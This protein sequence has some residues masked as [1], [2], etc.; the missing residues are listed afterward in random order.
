LTLKEDKTMV[1]HSPTF[2]F[3]VLRKDGRTLA[4]QAAMGFL[5]GYLVLHPVSMLIFQWLDPRIAAAMTHPSKESL[6]EEPRFLNT[7][8]EVLSNR[9][10][11]SVGCG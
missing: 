5:F 2:A 7:I 10:V 9:E 4:W 11:G 3:P 8:Q 6:V 1:L